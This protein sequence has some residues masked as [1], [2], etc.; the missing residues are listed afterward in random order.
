MKL[1]ILI[2]KEYKELVKSILGLKNFGR[3]SKNQG[4]YGKNRERQY[5]QERSYFNSDFWEYRTVSDEVRNSI[6]QHIFNKI[7]KNPKVL[8]LMSRSPNFVLKKDKLWD[9]HSKCSSTNS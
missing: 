1:A 3:K 7:K 5:R 8:K 2:K 6:K 4:Q 9:I